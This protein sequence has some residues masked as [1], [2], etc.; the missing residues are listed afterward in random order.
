MH[1]MSLAA[2]VLDIIESYSAEHGF[3]KVVALR[4]SCGR[5]S[6]VD[7]ATFRFAFEVQA[8]DTKAADAAVE[9]DV[10]RPMVSCFSCGK[11]SEVS[12]CAD[13]CPCCGGIDVIL[14]GGLEE[15]KIIDMEVE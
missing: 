15:L 7:P 1:E 8:R 4:L 2:A 11:Q 13:P 9:F 3:Q 12:S 10:C 14:T 5:L 6:C